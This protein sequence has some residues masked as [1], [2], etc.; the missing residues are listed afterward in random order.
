MDIEVIK[1]KRELIDTKMRAMNKE[2]L[3]NMGIQ[4]FLYKKT[5]SSVRLSALVQQNFRSP[6]TRYDILHG[7][8]VFRTCQI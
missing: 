5:T 1:S 6:A 8:N 3:K 2:L 4:F 7:L